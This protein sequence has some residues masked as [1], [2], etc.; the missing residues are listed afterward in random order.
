MIDQLEVVAIVLM[1]EIL[2]VVDKVLSWFA[3]T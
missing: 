1:D 2:K 3:L